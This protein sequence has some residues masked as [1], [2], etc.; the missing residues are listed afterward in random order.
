MTESPLLSR[1][2]N[3]KDSLSSGWRDFFPNQS[4]IANPL[5]WD[6]LFVKACPTFNLPR[7]MKILYDSMKHF[8][9]FDPQEIA[10]VW[11]HGSMVFIFSQESI[12]A[13][14]LVLPLLCVSFLRLG[15]RTNSQYF[16][17]HLIRARYNFTEMSLRHSN[18]KGQHA[19][20]F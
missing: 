11:L 5:F 19:V 8:S 16:M 12:L 4:S 7:P 9:F 10:P 18:H 3:S 17:Y 15:D 6:R 1:I 2:E 20:L 13:L 14:S